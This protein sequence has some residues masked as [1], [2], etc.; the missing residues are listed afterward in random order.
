MNEHT[1]ITFSANELA[2]VCNAKII[3]T[4]HTIIQKIYQLFGALIPEM[5]QMLHINKGHLPEEV[6]SK[7]AK[8]SRGEQYQ[9]L[10][11][12]MLDYPRYFEKADSFAIRTFFWWGNFFSVNLQL[13]GA[14]KN[15]FANRLLEQFSHL[16]E[17]GYWLCIAETPWEHHFGKANF[18]QLCNCTIQQFE[19][20]LLENEFIKISKKLPLLHW[21]QA[22]EFVTGTFNEM[23]ELL[24]PLSGTQAVK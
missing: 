24:Q 18:V 11:Y 13:G 14:Y 2:L 5:E 8:I 4:K 17:K 6:F 16:Q 1:K 10:P 12:V 9:L 19:S 20:V 7:S 15:I 23:L 21:E 22:D 3:L